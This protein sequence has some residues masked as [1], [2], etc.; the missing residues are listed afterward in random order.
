MIRQLFIIICTG[1][2]FSLPAL[3]QAGSEYQLAGFLMNQ[4]KYEEALPLLKQIYE[5]EPGAY[6]I[7]DR[8]AECHIQLKQYEEAVAI[9]NTFLND[10]VNESNAQI[11]LGELYHLSG[12]TAKAFN[13]WSKNLDSHRNEIQVYLS[14]ANS[15][16][17][18][19]E[20]DKAIEVYLKG[21]SN[22]N[23]QQIFFGDLANAYMQA[24][25]Y[26]EAVSE[27]LDLLKAVPNQAGYI[28]RT[29]L[30]YND[31]LIFDLTILE[32]G[33][34]LNSTPVRNE[35]YRTFYD[36]QIW[37]LLENKLYRRAYST[38]LEFENRTSEYTYSLFRLGQSL[39]QNKEYE[40]AQQAFSYYADNDF[41]ETRWRSL[42]E[43]AAVNMDWAK[44]LKDYNLDIKSDPDSLYR[45]AASTLDTILEETQNYSRLNRVFRMRAEI[46]LDHIFDL[47]KTEE[48]EKIMTE[49]SGEDEPADL[50]YLRGRIHIAKKEFPQARI[51]LTKANKMENIGDLAQKTR[52]F[53]ALSDFFAGDYEF[54]K[55]QLK[56]LGRQ[57]TSYYANDAL[58]LRLWI[59]KG[60]SSDST[61]T[62]LDTFSNAY[63]LTQTGQKD[64]AKVIYY[65]MLDS[66]EYA[67][68]HDDIMILMPQYN[69]D[70]TA[71][72][73]SDNAMEDLFTGQGSG[74]EN[75]MWN[76]A[77]IGYDKLGSFEIDRVIGY[78][79]DLILRYPE[80]I[81]APLAREILQELIKEKER[82]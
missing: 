32:I 25:K 28:Q 11:R 65:S 56:S 14:T 23:N 62:I 54:A 5:D 45:E 41:R 46:S 1:L 53:L 69:I 55:I 42:E 31:P 27:W 9:M 26:D 33:D 44:Y 77:K 18:R 59:Q 68:I 64:S 67:V 39:K 13:T 29:L 58:Q 4:Q 24:G 8:L 57:N 51:A 82:S 70:A 66:N 36:F 38:A 50:F 63:Y 37:L 74:L 19:R 6:I 78:F 21:R 61:G 34:Y 7:A 20:F 40:L 80:G 47:T 15:M 76:R 35:N 73:L 22:F 43:M 79:E 52:Y 10:P 49:L 75:L 60:L 12:D 3:G 30:R 17:D 2:I 72:Y 71:Y 81:Y 48:I 16:S